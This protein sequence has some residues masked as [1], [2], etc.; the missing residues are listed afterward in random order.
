MEPVQDIVL[1]VTSLENIGGLHQFLQQTLLQS[2]KYE[3]VTASDG[4]LHFKPG[5]DSPAPTVPAEFFTF[6]QPDDLPQYSLPTNF[7]D[8]LRL[9]GYSL[10]FNRQEEIQITGPSGSPAT[11][12]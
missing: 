12:H 10:H 7:G 11:A 2:S 4:I 6:T 8:S 5:S 3:L 1:D 9:H